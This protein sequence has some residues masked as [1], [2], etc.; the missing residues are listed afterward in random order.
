MKNEYIKYIISGS[1]E[2]I[3]SNFCIFY[4]LKND[5]N[6]LLH[7]LIRKL[8]SDSAFPENYLDLNYI[9]PRCT[10]ILIINKALIFQKWY[11]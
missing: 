6:F 7:Y 9:S 4:N 1:G 3:S 5:W 2:F 10:K 11:Q 8:D